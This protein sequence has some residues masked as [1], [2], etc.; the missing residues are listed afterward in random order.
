MNRLTL[1]DFP[2]DTFEALNLPKEVALII[3]DQWEDD[4]VEK[5]R[6]ET[7]KKVASI[8]N[9]EAHNEIIRWE[10]RGETIHLIFLSC[11]CPEIM[12]MRSQSPSGRKITTHKASNCTFPMEFGPHNFMETQ[13]INNIFKDV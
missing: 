13:G 8:I 1:R 2:F 9:V 10:D 4:L 3:A 7:A 11:N 6:K 5:W 12:I